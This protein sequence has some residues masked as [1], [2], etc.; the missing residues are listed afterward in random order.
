MKTK[1]ELLHIEDSKSV[2]DLPGFDFISDNLIDLSEKLE[3]P[4][5]LFFRG[6]SPIFTK[7]NI[8]T[9]SGQAKS[10]KSF[11]VLLL[12]SQ[13]LDNDKDRQILILDTE[14]ARYNVQQA[15]IRLHHLLEWPNDSNNDRLKFL[16][17]REKSTKEREYI[18]FSSI[19][20]IRPD[21]VF[22]DGIRDLLLNF[23]DISE[24]SQLINKLM[25]YSSLYGT[26]ICCV[27]HENKVDGNLRGHA[28]SELQNKCE[29]VIQV[30]SDG[31]IS[32]VIGRYC[33]NL[34][35]EDF[36]FK[37][38]ENGLPEFCEQEFK[39]KNNEMLKSLFNEILQATCC[40]SHSDL[41]NKVAEKTGKVSRTAERYIKEAVKDNII[42]KNKIGMYYSFENNNLIYT[43]ND[44]LPF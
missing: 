30:V 44:E 35:F 34:P 6:Q 32:K 2:D 15:A 8:S 26:H 10:R 22:I 21:F 37:V 4:V 3:K 19:E 16:T 17:L 39:P 31:N 42:V 36:H 18:V 41:C 23:N 28:G 33:R 9:I 13:I 12:A 29:T 11:L 43:E 14:Q 1:K 27:L 38:N 40:L 24:S 25:K 20:K 5:P 7:G